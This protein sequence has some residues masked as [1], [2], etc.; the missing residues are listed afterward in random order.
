MSELL[1][2]HAT[3]TVD[4]D[5]VSYDCNKGLWGVS[6]H[7]EDESQVRREAEYYFIQYYEDGEYDY[8]N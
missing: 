6:G 3:R 4:G 2:K 7:V 5:I 1:F 8:E